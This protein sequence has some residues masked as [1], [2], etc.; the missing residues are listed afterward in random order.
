MKEENLKGR[1]V[2]REPGMGFDEHYQPI[3]TTDFPF[4]EIERALNE[5]QEIAGP[6]TRGELLSAL[7]MFLERVVDIR[8][9]HSSAASRAV[10]R[11]IIALAWVVS[12]QMFSGISLSTLAARLEISKQC[13]S[14]YS[15]ELSARFGIE[16]AAQQRGRS[17]GH[18]KRL[19]K[20]DPP[21]GSEG[22]EEDNDRQNS[23]S[24]PVT[25]TSTL[26]ESEVER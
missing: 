18:R 9:L 1:F 2:L 16:N 17:G 5:S 24:K 26:P 25:S 3:Q 6:E 15:A 22:V 11:R 7:R 8:S 20:K 13:L 10:G 12:P 14:K 19:R 21:D 23:L 4:A